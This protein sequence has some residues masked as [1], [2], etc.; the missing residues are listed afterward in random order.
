MNIL[1]TGCSGFIGRNIISRLAH[2]YKFWGICRDETYTPAGVNIIYGDIQ[3]TSW[4]KKI[5]DPIDVV[6]HLAQSLFYK[7]FPAGTLDMVNVNIVSTTV[8]LEWARKNK[9]KKFIFAS[10]GN[11]Y[12]SK[13]DKAHENDVCNPENMYAVTKMSSELII[14]QYSPFFDV[15]ILRLFGVYGPDQGRMMIY[16]TIN[17]IRNGETIFLADKKGVVFMPLHI[18]DCVSA[19]KKVIDQELKKNIYNLAGIEIVT[20]KDVVDII[21]QNTGKKAMVEFTKLKP[22]VLIAD[23]KQLYDEINFKPKVNIKEGLVEVLRGLK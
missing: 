2:D 6:L 21:E 1:I 5:K 20:L 7:E 11:V 8:L 19:I 12:G 15:V 9:V 23:S 3:D 16:N 18:A 4:L 13:V 17:K 14:R 10:S 22:T